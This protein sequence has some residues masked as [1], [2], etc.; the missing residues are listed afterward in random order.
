MPK[1]PSFIALRGAPQ[2]LHLGMRAT[3]GW[4]GGSAKAA[5]QAADVGS[6]SDMALTAPYRSTT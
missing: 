6:I 4:A 3:A 5:R 1:S 2:A